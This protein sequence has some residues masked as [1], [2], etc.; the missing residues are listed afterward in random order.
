VTPYPDD[1]ERWREASR[2]AA[3]AREL[4]LRLTV[5]GAR[6][7]DV[8]EAVEG[9][10]RAAGA[11]PAFPVNLSRNEQAAHYTPDPADDGTFVTGDLVK[12]DVGAHLDGAISDTADTVEVGGGHRYENLVRAARE[13]LRA[14]IAEVRPGVRVDEVSRAIAAAIRARG[15]KPMENLTG[16][17][18]QRYLLHA[19]KSIPNVPGMSDDTL[20]EGEIIA[21]EPFAT[22]GVGMIENGPFGNIVRFRV[23]PGPKDPVLAG[24]F[25]RFRTLPFT[26]RWVAGEE[27]RAALARARRF[28]QTYPVFVEQGR[29]LV[30]QA[31]HTVLVGSSGADVLSAGP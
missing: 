22:N 24:L 23:D 3:R 20:E 28:L 15:L 30:A 8:A 27:E 2:I 13:G 12:V 31:E 4:G 19:G 6:R 26:L 21:I 18:I 7:R 29:G 25:A 11:Q 14:G 5:P 1:L 17:S 10:I 16:H 9:S